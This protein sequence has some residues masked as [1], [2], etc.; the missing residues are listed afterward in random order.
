MAATVAPSIMTMPTM[1]PA[2]TGGVRARGG[3]ANAR[4]QCAK[5]IG[6]SRPES[7]AGRDG[8]GASSSGFI[9]LIAA[10]RADHSERAGVGKGLRNVAA[11]GRLWCAATAERQGANQR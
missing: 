5:A 9:V 11:V 10:M 7:G 4:H 2:A 3:R 6:T 8:G 1:A